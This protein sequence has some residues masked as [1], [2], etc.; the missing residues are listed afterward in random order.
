MM[1]FLERVASSVAQPA[2]R[3]QPMLGSI[4][5][6]SMQFSAA[7]AVAPQI[8]EEE[9]VAPSQPSAAAQFT[10]IKPSYAF[11]QGRSAS[12]PPRQEAFADERMSADLPLDV[13]HDSRA[14]Y[15]LERPI[16][17][18]QKKSNTTNSQ[19]QGATPFQPLISVYRE[20]PTQLQPRTSSLFPVASIPWVAPPG[21]ARGAVPVPSE[22]DEIHIHIGRIDVT[23]TAQPTLRQAPATAPR[24]SLNLDDYLRGKNGRAG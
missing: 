10:S 3:L 16:P 14:V 4:Y 7:D 20:P 15:E 11:E 12:A 6:P 8:V 9:S 17:E 2:G 21:E 1:T 13:P 23:A 18:P 19:Q 5:S 24:R 22:P